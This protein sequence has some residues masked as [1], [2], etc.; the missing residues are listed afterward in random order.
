MFARKRRR[1]HIVKKDQV[2]VAF[3]RRR[4]EGLAADTSANRAALAR[5]RRGVGRTPGEMPELWGMLLNGLPEELMSDSGQPT[6]AEWAIYTSLTLFALHQQSQNRSAHEE[7]VSLGSAVRKLVARPEDME[8]VKRR[9][10]AM[11]TAQS[12]TEITYYLRGL[13]QLMRTPLIP[14][15]YGALCNDLYWVQLL[16]LA[17]AVKL[18]WGQDFYRIPLKD[19]EEASEETPAPDA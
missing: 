13:I 8:R 6:Q 7:G 12:V 17:P 1:E 19:A 9:L 15:D 18:R 11:V 10:D 3:A 5:L 4:I 14:L 2:A 16:D